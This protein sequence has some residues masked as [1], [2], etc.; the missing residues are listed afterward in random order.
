[1]EG[2]AKLYEEVWVCKI[3]SFIFNSYAVY[4]MIMLWNS[5]CCVLTFLIARET[6]GYRNKKSS[7]IYFT[8]IICRSAISVW[9]SVKNLC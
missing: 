8:T 9:M 6:T 3:D 2:C 5:T 4:L 7:Y 1:M